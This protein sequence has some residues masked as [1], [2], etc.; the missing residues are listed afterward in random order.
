MTIS[1]GPG[2]NINPKTQLHHISSKKIK[3]LFMKECLIVFLITVNERLKLFYA[4]LN[5]LL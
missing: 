2:E 1:A 4:K 3:V 5:N